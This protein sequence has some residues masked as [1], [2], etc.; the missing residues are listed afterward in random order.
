MEYVSNV[1][2]HVLN[3]KAI[4]NIVRNVKKISYCLTLHVYNTVLKNMKL[5]IKQVN[6]S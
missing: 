2:Y 3:V 4:L 1:N 6:V 5:I